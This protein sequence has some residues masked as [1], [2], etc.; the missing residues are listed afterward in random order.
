MLIC[1]PPL[2]SAGSA[3]P[4]A[5]EPGF[6]E[7][8]PVFVALSSAPCCAS[9]PPSEFEAEDDDEAE[10]PESSVLAAEPS[11]PWQAVSERPNDCRILT[12]RR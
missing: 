1:P 11:P 7:P 5:D 2:P 8:S 4:L 12:S 9:P 3:E 6:D 10:E